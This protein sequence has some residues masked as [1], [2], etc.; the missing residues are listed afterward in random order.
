MVHLDHC[1]TPYT[2]ETPAIPHNFSA[3]VAL[4]VRGCVL[5][6]L[7]YMSTVRWSTFVL[8]LHLKG[9]HSHWRTLD[10]ESTSVTTMPVI[11]MTTPMRVNISSLDQEDWCVLGSERCVVFVC[12]GGA[13]AA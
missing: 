8:C 7:V 13:G 10:D 6:S 2:P 11:A 5:C 4:S 3:V 9:L 12:N 1:S